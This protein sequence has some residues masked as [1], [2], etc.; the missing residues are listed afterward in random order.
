VFTAAATA[1]FGGLLVWVVLWLRPIR[2]I[3]LALAGSGYQRNLALPHNAYGMNGLR[4]LHD[5]ATSGSGG[6]LKRL[7]ANPVTLTSTS[8]LFDELGRATSGTTILFLAL[9]GASDQNG[10]FL[11]IDRERADPA[12]ARLYIKDLIKELEQRRPRRFVVVL[13]ATQ[14]PSMIGLGVLHNDFA[15]KLKTLEPQIEAASNLV[16]LSASDVDQRSWVS[17]RWGTTVFTHYL[18]EAL[19]GRQKDSS[20]R[21]MNVERLWRDVRDNVER[22]SLAN[23]GAAQTPV[24]LPSTTRARTFELALD[25]ASK[26]SATTAKGDGDPIPARLREEWA[27]V[28]RHAHDLEATVPAPAVVTPLL[29]RTY[30]DWLIRYDELVR[31]RDDACVAVKHTLEAFAARIQEKRRIPLDASGNSLAMPAAEGPPLA[32]PTRFQAQFNAIWTDPATLKDALPKLTAEMKRAYAEL[33]Y[34]RAE[35]DPSPANL[36]TATTLLDDL[37]PPALPR[38]AEIHFLAMLARDAPRDPS[39]PNAFQRVAAHALALRARAERAALGAKVGVSSDSERVAPWVAATIRQADESRRK[40]E[41]LVF[42][43]DPD[44]SGW[45]TAQTFLDTADRLYGQAEADAARVRSALETCDQALSDLPY[46][47]YW[48]ANLPPPAAGSTSPADRLI[49]L[50]A[51][52]YD[53]VDQLSPVT[54]S[55]SRPIDALV[56]DAQPLADGV[57]TLHAEFNRAIE[58]RAASYV[59]LNAVLKTPFLST[60]LREDV[61]KRLHEL[62]PENNPGDTPPTKSELATAQ[63]VTSSNALLATRRRAE[64]LLAVLGKDWFDEAMTLPKS[65][66]DDQLAIDLQPYYDV[67]TLVDSDK[68]TS[69]TIGHVSAQIGARWRLLPVAITRK[70]QAL[71]LSAPGAIHPDLVRSDRLARRLP[72]SLNDLISP[73]PFYRIALLQDLLT[74]QARRALDDH[75]FGQEDDAVPYYRKACGL[76]L[77]NVRAL[78]PQKADRGEALALRTASSKTEGLEVSGPG[79]LAVTTERRI[80]VEFQLRVPAGSRVPE[81]Y[82]VVWLSPLKADLLEVDA[83]SD[84]RKSFPVTAP[85]S[86]RYRAKLGLPLTRAVEA[87]PTR[88][89]TPE[90]RKTSIVLDGRYR[91]QKLRWEAPV[92]FHPVAEITSVRFPMPT[93]GRVAVVADPAVFSRYGE[94]GGALAIVL[95]CSGSMAGEMGRSADGTPITKYQEATAALRQVLRR[96]SRGTEVSLWVFGEAIENNGASTSTGTSPEQTIV[97]KLPPTRW[98]PDDS[99]LIDRVMTQVEPPALRPWNESPIVRSMIVARDGL[100]ASQGFKTLLVLTDGKDNRF[101]KDVEMNRARKDI[102]TALRDAF[103]NSDI[104]IN[105]IGYKLPDAEI[106][107]ARQQFQVIE[108]LPRPGRFFSVKEA[109]QLA[110]VLAQALRPNLRCSLQSMANIPVEALTVGRVGDNERWS[111]SSPLL[112]GYKLVTQAGT[113]LEREIIVNRGD[114]LLVTLTGQDTVSAERGLY[115]GDASPRDRR[116]QTTGWRGSIVR[117]GREGEGIE[118]WTT[119][120]KLATPKESA[121]EMIKP[122][123]VWMEAQPLGA[124]ASPIAQRWSYQTGLPAPAWALRV[125]AWPMPARPALQVWWD[126]AQEAT[127]TSEVVR[128]S[129]FR[130]TDEIPARPVKVDGLTIDLEMVSVETRKVEVSP[131][132]YRDESCLLIRLHYPEGKP[133]WVRP[134]GLRTEGAEH[135]F[136]KSANKYTGLFWPVTPDQADVAL[137]GLGLVSLAE[138]KA[139]CERR[140]FILEQQARGTPDPRDKGPGLVPYPDASTALDL[141]MPNLKDTGSSLP[142]PL[143]S[144][145]PP[146]PPPPPQPPPLPLERG[147]E[148]EPL[149][150]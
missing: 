87:D 89:R 54:G 42:S 9:H 111:K 117:N 50:F 11:Y 129:D 59:Q 2:P 99:S 32:D 94:A 122:R 73:S 82:P 131:G 5:L 40:G 17:D 10:P 78:D 110:A 36:A 30:R 114:L 128:L 123:E 74:V 113:R 102:P 41:D 25:P 76:Y 21:R 37:A 139:R 80:G 4:A 69:D 91:G 13:D 86:A 115:S 35:S 33:A 55:V 137:E 47:A 45:A 38:P 85:L 109:D 120:E 146:P 24:I 141:A 8:Q 71:N 63:A 90:T 116:E 92:T 149:P 60:R 62:S 121:L 19:S 150:G 77:D 44:G 103:R 133:Y 98:D 100:T 53:L 135:R 22:W 145:P 18:V 39:N 27:E 148:L 16:F 58:D 48:A 147:A 31:A 70:R 1:I 46:F 127:F 12:P 6:R 15:E 56:T 3:T 144:T 72:G 65:T 51:R 81:G 7:H 134:Q 95:D 126:A 28:W 132:V 64:L 67:K 97:Q 52:T 142:A 107:A 140:G 14:A 61:V 43:N 20:E 119:L 93:T 57:A 49:P 136:Y 34:R 79:P 96:V 26:P 84:G 29:W 108:E 105:V 83:A 23:R 112:G 68:F 101:E 118:V 130:S 104:E 75:W 138:F 124:S 88:F 125:P 66:Q 106:M 143:P